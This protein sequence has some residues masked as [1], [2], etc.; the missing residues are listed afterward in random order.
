MKNLYILI[1]LFITIGVSAQDKS[2]EITNSVGSAGVGFSLYDLTVKEKDSGVTDKDTTGAI[3]FPFDYEYGVL[4]WLGAGG[5]FRFLNFIEGDSNTN[6]VIGIDFALRANIHFLRTKRIDWLVAP[7]FG[8]SY[9]SFKD[10]G[11]DNGSAKGS[12]TNF[13]FETVFRIYFGE[14]IG[15]FINGGYTSY[16]YPNIKLVSDVATGNDLSLKL[17]GKSFGLGLQYKF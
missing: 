7:T 12:G 1:L 3:V 17:S 14:H 16:N 8:Y 11:V 13:G 6:Q 4:N 15:I 5:T 10:N 9:I 2:F